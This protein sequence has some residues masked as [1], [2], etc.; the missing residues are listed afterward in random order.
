MPKKPRRSP[1][2][3]RETPQPV[4]ALA[5]ARRLDGSG[6]VTMQIV[7]QPQDA[8]RFSDQLVNALLRNGR[9]R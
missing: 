6:A 7:L 4:P 2:R 5:T 3:P 9:R 8:G 1:R